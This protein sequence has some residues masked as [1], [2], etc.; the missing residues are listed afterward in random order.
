MNEIL[1]RTYGGTLMTVKCGVSCDVVENRSFSRSFPPQL[2]NSL[3]FYLTILFAT[4]KV[5]SV[6]FSDIGMSCLKMTFK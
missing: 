5:L 4:V 3:S 6:K 1:K 2:V